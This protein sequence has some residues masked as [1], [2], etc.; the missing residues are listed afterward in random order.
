MKENKLNYRLV[1]LLLIIAILFLT[2]VTSKY[3]GGVL[4]K[5]F[6]ILLPFMLAFVFA[7]VLDPFVKFLENKG[8]RKKLAIIIVVLIVLVI[9]VTVLCLTLPMIY[10]Q[11]LV[12]AKS[13]V[14]FLQS[15]STKFDVNLGDIQFRITDILNTLIKQVGTYVSTGTIDILG[16]SVNVIANVFIILIV[17]IYLLFDMD[18]I[19]AFVKKTCRRFS[20]RTYQF[21]KKLDIEMGNYFHGLF[22]LIFVTLIEYG[23]LYKL[24]NHPNWLIIGV[25]MAVLTIIP[26]FGGIIGNVI[27][28]ITASV[29][30][31]PVLIGTV[32]ICLIFS[33]IDG[34]LISPRI[35]GKTNNI[36]PIAIIFAIGA[37]GALFGVL[38]IAIALPLYI[39]LHCAYDFYQADIKD[40]LDDITA[41]R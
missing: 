26:Y 9:F 34:Y 27:A 20:Y 4:V 13:I 30:S 11:L 35:Y 22:I 10:E 24:I 40:K 33:N 28:I 21:V 18:Y 6:N 16:K 7:Y 8:V 39:A 37:G 2:L 31:T 15:I 38:G 25:L 23:L 17:G 19:R 1:N 32:L 14:E 36:S 41:E 5:I 3:W 29:V 12:F